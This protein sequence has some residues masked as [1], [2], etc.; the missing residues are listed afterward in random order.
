MAVF[1]EGREVG[2]TAG[3]QPAAGIEAFVQETL[4]RATR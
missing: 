2:R 1:S 4:S 3:A